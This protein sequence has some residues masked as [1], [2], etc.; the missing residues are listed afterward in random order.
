[1]SPAFTFENNP[2]AENDDYESIEDEEY[3]VEFIEE[4]ITKYVKEI[5][6]YEPLTDAI[7]TTL[8]N[9]KKLSND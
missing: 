6:E 2:I 7:T 8:D 3:Y 4:E 9:P 1:M 5:I